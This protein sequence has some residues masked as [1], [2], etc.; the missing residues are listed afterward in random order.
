MNYVFSITAL[1]APA[2]DAQTC[3]ALRQRAEHISRTRH[4]WLWKWTDRR[5]DGRSQ[6]ELDR[7]QRRRSR[8]LSLCV[9]ALGVVLLIPGM[10][11]PQTLL[12]PTLAGI[13]GVAWGLISLLSS[14]RPRHDPFQQAADALLRGMADILPAKVTFTE[15][16]M[17]VEANGASE[18]TPYSQFQAVIDQPELIL[19][20]FGQQ[21]VLLLPKKALADQAEALLSL[22]TQR[23]ANQ[24][25]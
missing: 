22:L 8:A 25:T 13:F 20:S 23:T 4:P 9:L 6:E 11:N 12:L 3:Q 17:T 1:D 24:N 2:L 14:L 16:A 19:L 15:D 5:R 7:M 10:Q 18:T 21:S